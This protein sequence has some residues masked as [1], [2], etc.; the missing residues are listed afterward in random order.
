MESWRRS[1][2]RESAQDGDPS[3]IAMSQNMRAECCSPL[4]V[5]QGRIW[6]VVGSGLATVSASETREKPSIAEPSKP[7][8]S[9]N[10][11][12][13]SAGAMATDLR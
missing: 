5:V 1:T 9:S 4:L 7:M 2:C 11:P 6:N 3:G 8:P 12:S 10:A 13:S